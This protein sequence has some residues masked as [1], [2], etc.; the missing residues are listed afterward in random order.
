MDSHEETE[1]LRAAVEGYRQRVHSMADKLQGYWGDVLVCQGQFKRLDEDFREFRRTVATEDKL[2]SAVDLLTT[3]IDHL[4]ETVKPLRDAMA[5][6]V[7]LV[8]SLV[9]VA[10]LG[11]VIIQRVAPNGLQ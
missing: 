1:A 11:L 5:K 7:W 4:N 6:V 8:I 10:V 3:K 9:I 2:T